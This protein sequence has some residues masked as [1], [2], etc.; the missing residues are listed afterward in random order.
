[1]I[2]VSRKLFCVI[3]VGLLTLAVASLCSILH[4]SMD[5]AVMAFL[6]TWISTI[7]L[8]QVGDFFP[9]EGK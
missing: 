2:V 1:M 4:L 5:K 7:L 8:F 3:L 9:H 6:A